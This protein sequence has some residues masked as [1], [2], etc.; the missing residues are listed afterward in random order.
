MNK[1]SVTIGISAYNEEATVARLLNSILSQKKEKFNLEKIILISDGSTDRTAQMAAGVRDRKRRIVVINS[2]KNLGRIHRINQLVKKATSDYLILLDA[3]EELE[4]TMSLKKLLSEFAKQ[5]NV[6]LVSGNPYFK[7][8]NSFVYKCIGASYE[9]YSRIRYQINKGHNILGCSG[10]M[11]AMKREFYS[12]LQIPEDIY[13]DDSFIYLKCVVSGYKF[14]NARKAT[15]AHYARTDLVSHVKRNRRYALTKQHLFKLFGA[16]VDQEM[17]IPKRILI[18]EFIRMVLKKPIYS[19]GI[20]MIN[21][22]SIMKPGDKDWVLNFKKAKPSLCVGIPAYNESK[23][24]KRLLR[25]IISQKCD[26]YKLTKIIVSSD[27][28]TDSTVRAA[29][30]VL[31]ERLIVIENKSRRGIARGLNQIISRSSADILVT[32]D[33]DIAI[34][35][36]NFLSE[37]VNPIVEGQADLTSSEIMELPGKSPVAKSLA[38]SMGI[39]RTLFGFNKGQNIYTCHGLARA[40]SKQFYSR[41][42]FPV[43]IANDM[44]SYLSCLKNGM[45]YSLAKSAIAHYRTPENFQDYKKQCQ[46]FSGSA[47]QMNEYFGKNMISGHLKIPVNRYLF[48]LVICLPRILFNIHLALIYALIHTRAKISVVEYTPKQTWDI[49]ITSK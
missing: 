6:A 25:Q 20:F 39:K 47:A 22:Y 16:I 37:L 35:S 17:H 9:A 26:N 5:D 15:I 29:K 38:F 3:D 24:I 31:D 28:S 23:N 49:A 34:N 45:R 48:T 43:S 12:N 30:S 41:L 33:G 21:R 19:I 11:L 10:G 32:L 44:Y 46:R 27:G 36:N 40:Y 13:A 1:P 42:N 14:R 7:G 18:S 4:D 8:P 2:P